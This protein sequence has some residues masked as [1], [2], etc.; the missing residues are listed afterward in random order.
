MGNINAVFHSSGTVPE[1]KLLLKSQQ[2]HLIVRRK[3]ENM[4]VM[5]IVLARARRCVLE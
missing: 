2:L 1:A 5:Y 3:V 4:F